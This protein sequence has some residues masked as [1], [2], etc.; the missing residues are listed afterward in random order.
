MLLTLESIL[1]GEKKKLNRK[2]QLVLKCLVFQILLT[3][4]TKT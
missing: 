1:K 2:E 4:S 3:D